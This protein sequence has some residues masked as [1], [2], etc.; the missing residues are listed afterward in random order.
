MEKKTNWVLTSREMFG[1]VRYSHYQKQECYKDF[2]ISFV[3]RRESSS[4]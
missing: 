1:E 3:P 4:I 2:G